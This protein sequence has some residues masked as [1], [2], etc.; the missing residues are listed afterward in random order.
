MECYYTLN[1]SFVCVFRGLIYAECYVAQKM[2]HDNIFLEDEVPLSNG[3]MMS[4]YKNTTTTK[5]YLTK[6]G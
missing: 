2:C 6:W 4:L 1:D 5:F 3:F